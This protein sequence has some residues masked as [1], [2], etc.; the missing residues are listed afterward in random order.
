M[1]CKRLVSYVRIDGKWTKIGYYGTE[2]KQ[3]EPLDLV[4]EEEDRQ[5]KE[6]LLELQ[7]E[8]KQDKQQSREEIARIRQGNAKANL[9]GINVKSF[10]PSTDDVT[11]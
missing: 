7:L 6:R 3:F 2:C 5:R 9:F 10:C 11:P 8:I 4:M 1:Y